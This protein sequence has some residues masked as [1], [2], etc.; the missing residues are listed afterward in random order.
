M[1]WRSRRVE[2]RTSRDLQRTGWSHI[3]QGEAEIEA[4]QAL[5]PGRFR[6]AN[7]L[8]PFKLSE[9]NAEEIG[10]SILYTVVAIGMFKLGEAAIPENVTL[11]L[12]CTHLAEVGLLACAFMHG[13]VGIKTK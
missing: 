1:A 6:M 11:C 3:A 2:A 8:N 4:G 9:F 7:F 10:K 13:V 5:D 12:N